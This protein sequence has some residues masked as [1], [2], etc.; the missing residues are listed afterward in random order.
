MEKT[1]WGIRLRNRG[2]ITR[3]REIDEA[4]EPHISSKS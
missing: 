3:R 4:Y 2:E 1:G